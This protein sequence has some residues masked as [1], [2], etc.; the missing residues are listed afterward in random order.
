[1]FWIPVPVDNGSSNKLPFA[2]LLTPL[3][4]IAIQTSVRRI[5]SK[6]QFFLFE[7]VQHLELAF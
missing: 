6:V 3:K 4:Y 2:L 5:D 7:H 1:M